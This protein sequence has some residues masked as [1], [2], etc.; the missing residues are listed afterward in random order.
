MIKMCYT[1]FGT[2]KYAVIDSVF[3]VEKKITA[4]EERGFYADTITNKRKY[5][6]KGVPG[7]EIDRNFHN[8]NTDDNDTLEA[9]K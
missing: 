8:G 4:L 7:D 6:P 9:M 1:I 3:Y 5:W 2:V